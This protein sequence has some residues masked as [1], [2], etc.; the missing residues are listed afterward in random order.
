[1]Q[2]ILYI[3]IYNKNT[4]YNICNI[5]IYIHIYIYIFMYTVSFCTISVVAEICIGTVSIFSIVIQI[6]RPKLL[7]Q[8]YDL[9]I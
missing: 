8:G 6:L 1:M 9:T 3:Y 5:Y 4:I 2:Y 7:Q